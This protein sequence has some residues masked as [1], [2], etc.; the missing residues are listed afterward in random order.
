M[1]KRKERIIPAHVLPD[2]HSV[3]LKQAIYEETLPP[4]PP[5]MRRRKRKE[6]RKG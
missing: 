6:E 4:C 3:D 2:N 1:P 5:K